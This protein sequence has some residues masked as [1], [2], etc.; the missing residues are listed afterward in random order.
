[1][2]KQ[3]DRK[4]QQKGAD[5]PKKPKE[6]KK[7]QQRKEKNM[8]PTVSGLEAGQKR[9]Q[10]PFIDKGARP[11]LSSRSWDDRNERMTAA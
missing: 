10:E 2:A 4:N 5:G 11:L 9:C 8:P 3:P 6:R 1:M 7:R